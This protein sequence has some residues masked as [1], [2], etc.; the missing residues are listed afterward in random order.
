MTT[1]KTKLGMIQFRR[2]FSETENRLNR[3][4]KQLY[5]LWNDEKRKQLIMDNALHGTDWHKG[6]AS[7]YLHYMTYL[8]L[9][10]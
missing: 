8:K 5:S 2:D 1:A 3:N 4:Y 7:E 10:A 6:Y 9:K